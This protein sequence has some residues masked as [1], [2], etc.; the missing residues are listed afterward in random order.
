L[1]FA[2]LFLPVSEES[3]RGDE[4]RSSRY[5]R[6]GEPCVRGLGWSL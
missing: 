1:K 2:T 3:F 5:H 4:R 6:L